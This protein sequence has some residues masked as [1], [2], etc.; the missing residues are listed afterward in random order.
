[1]AHLSRQQRRT[2][3]ES[4]HKWPEDFGLW[5]IVEGLEQKV[6]VGSRDYQDCA[7]VAAVW[8][9]IAGPDI[10][11]DSAWGRRDGNESPGIPLRQGTLWNRQLAAGATQEMRW[12]FWKKRLLEVASDQALVN[13]S[14][15]ETAQQAE[16]VMSEIQAAAAT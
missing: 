2:P 10:Y 11:Q 8:L 3:V 16:R 12:D 1:M 14:V 9:I 7:E 4:L 13:H 6:R 15:R 5:N